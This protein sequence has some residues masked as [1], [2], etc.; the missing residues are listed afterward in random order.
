ML[1]Y[2]LFILV[3]IAI[4]LAVIAYLFAGIG[5]LLQMIPV[6]KMNVPP[7]HFVEYGVFVIP[8]VLFGGLGFMLIYGLNYWYK[9]TGRVDT[10]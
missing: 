1:L 7:A 5:Y 10:R 2:L 6:F 9:I 4:G 8:L 3:V